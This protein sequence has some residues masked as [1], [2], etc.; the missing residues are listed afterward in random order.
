MPSPL[1]P[2]GVKPINP[3]PFSPEWPQRIRRDASQ[4]VQPPEPR[5]AD[6]CLGPLRHVNESRLNICD[7]GVA[8]T[9][10]PNSN[11]PLRSR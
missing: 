1:S 10:G 11:C 8:F 3:L 7:I 5:I 2:S 4:V 6:G 9:S